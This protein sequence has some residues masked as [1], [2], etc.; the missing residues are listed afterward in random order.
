[1]NRTIW[2]G[3]EPGERKPGNVHKRWV[4]RAN[5][6]VERGLISV[7][8]AAVVVTVVVVTV[9]VVVVIN[10][11]TKVTPMKRKVQVTPTKRKRRRSGGRVATR[12]SDIN[13]NTM[14]YAQLQGNKLKQEQSPAA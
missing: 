5:V 8:A 3:Y 11:S 4:W 1:M 7:A 12:T 9:V 2:P 14:T 10:P 13:E 6:E